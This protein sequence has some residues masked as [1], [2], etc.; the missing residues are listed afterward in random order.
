MVDLSVLDESNEVFI[1]D[2][3]GFLESGTNVFIFKA[4]LFEGIGFTT[5]LRSSFIDNSLDL[6]ST[7][8]LSLSGSFLLV[9]F[10]VKGI[11]NSLKI[12]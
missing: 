8:D 12:G 4:L 6:F 10:R 3:S 5:T 9:S 11:K 2:S 1:E 7:D